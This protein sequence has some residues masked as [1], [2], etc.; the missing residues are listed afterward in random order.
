M[1]AAASE[2]GLP[3]DNSDQ[4][5]F[6]NGAGGEKWLR[7]TE[8]LERGLTPLGQAAIDAAKPKPGERVLDIGCGAGPT[9][10]KLAQAVGGSG[11]V[12]GVDV[13]QPLI[14][15]A[16][17]R[18]AGMNNLHF[19]VADASAAKFDGQYDLLFSRFGVMF[20]ADPPGAFANLRHALKPGGR[21]AFVCWRAFKENSWAFVPFM[22][23]VPHLPPIARP[24]PNA[25]GPFAFAD[26]ERVKRILGEAGFADIAV[27]PFD[28]K[29]ANSNSLDEAVVFSSE[30]GPV[31]RVLADA[32]DEQRGKAVAAIRAILQK[33]LDD[34]SGLSLPAAC[35]IVTGRN[36]A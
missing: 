30:I 27:T 10:Q 12:L 4:I 21:L 26:G 33:R 29:M 20:F 9:S 7:S 5:A 6:W 36:P 3:A 11:E 14:A 19:T 28:T 16:K 8:R 13:S 23:A 2:S 25:P 17:Q 32:S 24:E 34:G 15:A 18:A 22:A 35:W 31:S 1:S